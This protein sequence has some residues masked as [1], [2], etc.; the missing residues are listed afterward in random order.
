[1]NMTDLLLA[2]SWVLSMMMMFAFGYAIAISAVQ[3]QR[4]AIW[5]RALN[6]IE[7]VKN[8][9]WNTDRRANKPPTEN[10]E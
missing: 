10:E 4:A 2:F 7:G 3:R 5:D 1:M 6:F 8:E 9:Y